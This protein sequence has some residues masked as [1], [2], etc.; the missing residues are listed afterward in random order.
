MTLV[1]SM[2]LFGLITF[3]VPTITAVGVASPIAHGQVII[4]TAIAITSD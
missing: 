4:S 2:V 3:I 1:G